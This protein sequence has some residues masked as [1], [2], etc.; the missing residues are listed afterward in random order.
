M[1]PEGLRRKARQ[2]GKILATLT[3]RCLEQKALAEELGLPIKTTERL[4]AELMAAGKVMV[5]ETRLTTVRRS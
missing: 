4:C 1:T 2:K 3:S 5:I